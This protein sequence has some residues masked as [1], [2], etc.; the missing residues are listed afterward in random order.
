MFEKLIEE[1]SCLDAVEAIAL[2]GSRAGETYDASSDY[3]VYLYCTGPVDE[4]L[5]REILSKYCSIIELGNQ[6]WELEDNCRLLNGVEIDILYRDLDS[7]TAD[8]AS[9]VEQ[10][11]ARNGYTTC[12]W[13]NL[14]SCK[15]LYDRDGRLAEAKQRF[16]VPYPA[17]LKANIIDRGWKLLRSSMPAYELQI[18]KA[19][20][21]Q[22]L[23]SINHRT[24]AFLESYFDVI[25]ALNEQTHPGEKRLMSICLD[26][27]NVLPADF[28]KNLNALFSHL[29]TQPESVPEDLDRIL[30]ELGK[31]L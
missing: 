3:D 25:F 31:I 17:Q 14:R 22:D 18:K 23:V 7:F 21:R 20:S 12:M 19:L 4:S 26:T 15:I 28:E 6:F 30:T 5:R 11:Q 29:F 24:A 8:V 9:V 27:C 16:S 13:H 10:Y 2:G 1:L